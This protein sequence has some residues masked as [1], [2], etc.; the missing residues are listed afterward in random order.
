MPQFDGTGPAG[1]GQLTGM[2]RG[3]CRSSWKSCPFGYTAPLNLTK[4]E[5][6]KILEAELRDIEAEK[7]AIKK[8]LSKIE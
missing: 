3:F 2:C 8:R 7:Q 5:E 4:D 1:Q 6:K